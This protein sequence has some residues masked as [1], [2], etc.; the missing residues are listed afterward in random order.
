[1]HILS[2]CIIFVSS[3]YIHVCPLCVCMCVCVCSG[4]P[5]NV[6]KRIRFGYSSMIMHEQSLEIMVHNNLHHIVKFLSVCTADG[7]M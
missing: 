1:M 3:V 6:L 7:S 2:A 5:I 4:K